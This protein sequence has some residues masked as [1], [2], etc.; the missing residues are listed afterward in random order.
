MIIIAMFKQIFSRHFIERFLPLAL[1]ML[2]T[3][4]HHIGSAWH[5]P[6][7]SWAVFFLGGLYL[8]RAAFGL[9]AVEAVAIDF[10]FFAMGGSTYCLSSAYPFLLP[11]YAALWF[12]GERLS[13]FT[14][15]NMRFFAVAACYWWAAASVAYLLTNGSFYWLSGK[16]A[17][18]SLSGYIQN[19]SIWYS[20]FV[21]RPMLYLI[22]AA[23]THA[24]F[25]QM[26]RARLALR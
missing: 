16:A 20:A 17:E 9:F 10:A 18:S 7:A 3:R 6:D 26:Q 8:R 23:I 15:H 14:E 24:A 4:F 19:A 22:V 11:A 13:R 25:V 2:A 21:T 12:A 1:L 5:L